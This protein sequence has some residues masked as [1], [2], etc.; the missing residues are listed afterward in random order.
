MKN[1]RRLGHKPEF[2]ADMLMTVDHALER[3][4]QLM[5]Q[6]REGAAPAGAAVGVD[7]GAIARSLATSVAR[8][9]RQL[10]L[11][12]QPHVSTRGHA[13]RLERVVGHLVNNALEATAPTKRVWLKLERYGSHARVQV[14]DEGVGMSPDFVRERLF[15]PF[16]STK[17]AGMGIGV[18]ES[19]QYVQELGGKVTVDS[20]EGAGTVVTLLLPLI[21]AFQP[22]DLHTLG[23]AEA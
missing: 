16:Q 21:E 1:A 7:L 18:Y 20:E 3:M 13:E 9:G 17:E 10:E 2:Q 15:K 5:L 22:S 12:L 6:L 23:E 11:D 14:G 4:R 8:R 19:F